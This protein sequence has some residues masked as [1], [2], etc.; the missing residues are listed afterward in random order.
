MKTNT[1]IRFASLVIFTIAIA[2]CSSKQTAGVT[3]KIQPNSKFSKISIGMPMK[4]VF[5]LIGE[6]TDRKI[7]TTGKAWI[8]FY[9]GSDG[10][11]C[12]ALYKGEGRIT[13]TG[14]AGFGG[15]AFK[16]YS[17]VHDPTETGY[18]K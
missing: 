6:P 11:R 7:Y 4:Q 5:D 10:A 12:E 17:I 13:F 2:G 8:P 16:A 3:G 15:G 14:G 9:F 18:N 1:L